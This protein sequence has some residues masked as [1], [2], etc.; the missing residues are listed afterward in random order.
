M[1]FISLEVFNSSFSAE[2]ALF[3]WAAEIEFE[4]AKHNSYAILKY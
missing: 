3:L 2:L 1:F 4:M